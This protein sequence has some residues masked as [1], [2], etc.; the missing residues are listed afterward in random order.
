MGI[1]VSVLKATDEQIR[2][3]Q[4]RPKEL[5]H[6]LT[7]TIPFAS[8]D[9]CFLSDYWAGL[10]HLLT[11]GEGKDK[12]LMHAIQKGEVSFRGTSDPTHALYCESVKSLA[13]ELAQLGEADLRARYEPEK[14]SSVYPGRYWLFPAFYEHS[15]Q[16]LLSCFNQLRGYATEAAKEGLGLIFCRY[17]DW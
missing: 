7:T 2:D 1:S 6:L 17:E 15:F 5:E 11:L 9:C 16:E 13:A 3:F 8:S 10:H 12:P 4:S 14:M